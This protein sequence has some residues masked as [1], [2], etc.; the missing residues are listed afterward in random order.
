MNTPTT[1]QIFSVVCVKNSIH[2]Y[3]RCL[4]L[5]LPPL[6]NRQTQ[7]KTQLDGNMGRRREIQLVLSVCI[8]GALTE[9]LCGTV[10]WKSPGVVIAYA[11]GRC[12]QV[13]AVLGKR[14]EQTRRLGR[15][16]VIF[17]VKPNGGVD[18]TEV[19]TSLIRHCVWKSEK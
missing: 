11:L 7:I 4:S 2:Q 15:T 14:E 13:S 6:G 16:G 9:G 10:I 1:Y 3:K 8:V 12:V 19:Y 17:M 18:I 5:S